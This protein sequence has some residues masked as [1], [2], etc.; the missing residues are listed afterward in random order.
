MKTAT[1]PKVGDRIIYLGRVKGTITRISKGLIKYE[2]LWDGGRAEGYTQKEW[3]RGDFELCG[4]STSVVGSAPASPLQQLSLEV[5][6]LSDCASA[7]SGAP[8]SS[9]SDIPVSPSTATLEGLQLVLPAPEF[10]SLQ[11]VPLANPSRS[12]GSA[13]EPL[14]SAIVFQQSQ[15]RSLI[16]NPLTFAS[17]TS[18]AYSLAPT[19]PEQAGIPILSL[20]SETSM[21]AGTMSNGLLYQAAS[22]VE[23]L[24]DR[25]CY[26]LESPGGLS[27]LSSRSPGQSR[28]EAQLKKMGVLKKGECINPIWLEEQFYLPANWTNP[29]EYKSATELLEIVE[30][31]SEIAS[32]PELLLLLLEESNIST[33]S[34]SKEK[35][36]GD[37][38]TEITHKSPRKRSSNLKPASGSLSACTSMKKGKPYISYQYS[39][40]V[41]DESSKRGWRTV[42]VGVPKFKR[43]AIAN[44]I[45]QGLAV[46]EILEALKR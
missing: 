46:A 28:L 12:K 3:N 34:Q 32:T 5:S 43:Q 40:D 33:Q 4:S 38:Y 26:W 11:P 24:K 9:S 7:T 35:I 18:K 42:K 22:L 15:K 44:L 29:S 16:T 14:T 25:D 30:P 17:K 23:P 19:N 6:T 41:R 37:L 13:K 21:P 39:Y 20:S 27:S 8:I 31:L 2:I 45:N 36:L 1:K 10:G